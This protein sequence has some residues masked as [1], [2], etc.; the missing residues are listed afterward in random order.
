MVYFTLTLWPFWMPGFHAGA[1]FK[2]LT[3]SSSRPLPTLRST[4]MLDKCPSV[5][6]TKL[7]NTF[8]AHLLQKPGVDNGY[9]FEEIFAR[10]RSTIRLW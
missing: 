6:T 3:A 9:F 1:N 10:Q 4:V 5:S 8:L 2:T 7:K